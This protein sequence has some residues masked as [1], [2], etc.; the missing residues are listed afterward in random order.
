[1]TGTDGGPD[2]GWGGYGQGLG[3]L[4][5]GTHLREEAKE[6]WAGV[7]GEKLRGLSRGL[8]PVAERGGSSGQAWEAIPSDL[9]IL[10]AGSKQQLVSSLV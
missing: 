4:G 6:K 2:G 9:L 5:R 10:K 1:M 7:L 8:L 3:A